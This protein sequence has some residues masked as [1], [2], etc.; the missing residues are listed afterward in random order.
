MKAI[1]CGGCAPP[2]QVTPPN[3]AARPFL[4]I[5]ESQSSDLF[6]YFESRDQALDHHRNLDY[7]DDLIEGYTAADYDAL[8]AEVERLRVA[9]KYA[10]SIGRGM[11]N[12]I[13]EL[14]ARAE[15]AEAKVEK[16]AAFARHV[17]ETAFD[18][19]NEGIRPWEHH[20]RDLAWRADA[21]INAQGESNG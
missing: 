5:R 3:E 18:F 13:R 19:V 16:L 14:R 21:A 15:A 1:E 17:R 10:A 7:P 11:L 9:D 4:L 20:M 6:E 2:V 12:E 8:R